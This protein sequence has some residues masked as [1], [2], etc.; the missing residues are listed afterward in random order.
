[1]ATNPWPDFLNIPKRMADAAAANLAA[2]ASYTDAEKHWEYVAQLNYDKGLPLDNNNA[3]PQ[4]PK[5]KV[6]DSNTGE[7]YTTDFAGLPS[8]DNF[9]PIK[10]APSTGTIVGSNTSLTIDQKLDLIGQVLLTIKSLLTKS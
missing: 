6:V 4:V 3:K 7:V 10:G 2:V 1:M 9:V 8:P 5:K